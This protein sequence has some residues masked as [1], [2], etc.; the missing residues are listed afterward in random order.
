[1]EKEKKR[2]ARSLLCDNPDKKG[3]KLST[4]LSTGNQAGKEKKETP[5]GKEEKKRKNG[6]SF[7]ARLR[8]R[9][10]VTQKGKG[11]KKGNAAPATFGAESRKRKKKKRE[12]GGPAQGQPGTRKGLGRGGKKRGMVPPQR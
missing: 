10:G 9:Q 3:R 1:M 12:K 2:E 6:V 5:K 11:K 7:R 4:C 8:N